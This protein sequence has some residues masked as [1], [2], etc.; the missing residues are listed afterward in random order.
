MDQSGGKSGENGCEGG[1]KYCGKG[2][3]TSLTDQMFYSEMHK[4]WP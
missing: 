4:L 2:E 3:N 1:G